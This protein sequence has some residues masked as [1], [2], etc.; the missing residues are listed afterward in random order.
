MQ[1]ITSVKNPAVQQARALQKKAARDESGLFLCEGEHMAGE[2]LRAGA[3][4]ALFVD[5]SLLAR[6]EPLT[7]Q[8][9][10]SCPVYA[11]PAHVLAALSLVKSPQGVAAVALQPAA[12]PLSALGARVLLLEDV[13]DPGNVGTLLRTLDA[14][15]FTGCILTPGCADPYGDKALRAT[16]GSVFRVPMAR[17]PSAGAAVSTLAASGFASYA[18]VLDGAPY[19]QRGPA[20]QKLC[21]LIGN[22]GAGLRPDTAQA[23][24]RRVRLPMRGGAE[25]LNAA[26]AGAVLMYD[27]MNR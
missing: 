7:R 13:Q 5:D 22:E 3:A 11:A 10:A 25:S 19:Y 26:I 23:C 14:A 1:A 27:L 9:P 8:A 6:Y 15:G 24:T 16:M 18:A 20:E 17:V 4:V 2:A 21:L 12:A